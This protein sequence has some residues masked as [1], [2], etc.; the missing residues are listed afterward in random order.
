MDDLRI[1]W[2][3]GIEMHDAYYRETFTLKVVLFKKINDFLDYGNM[4]GCI[5]KGYY[6]HSICGKDHLQKV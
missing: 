6:A 2:N 5:I 3:D 4:C 1:L